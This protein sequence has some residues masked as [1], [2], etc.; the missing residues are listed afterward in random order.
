MATKQYVCRDGACR[1]DLTASVQAAST[2]NPTVSARTAGAPPASQG[3]RVQIIC[4]KGHTNV[5]AE[6]QTGTTNGN[7]EE[8]IGLPP[9]VTDA[10]LASAA[11]TLAP[12]KALDRLDAFAQY[13]LGLSGIVSILLT[14]FGVFTPTAQSPWVFLPMSLFCLSLGLAIAGLTPAPLVVN[15]NDLYELERLYNGHV[16]R[17]AGFVWW[18]GVLFAIGV[19]SIPIYALLSK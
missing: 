19:F 9:T 4:L 15:V 7:R 8:V 10:L 17:R 14:G 18:A 12:D 6:A 11:L 2:A 1:E 13:L 5:F 16:R 3:W